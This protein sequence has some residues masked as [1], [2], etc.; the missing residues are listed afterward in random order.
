M[1]ALA[2]GANGSKPAAARQSKVQITHTSVAFCAKSSLQALAP[3][4]SSLSPYS[5][6]PKRARNWLAMLFFMP[7]AQAAGL[8]FQPWIR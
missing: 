1:S 2:R 8:L 3:D 7:T 5:G 6:W 4:R